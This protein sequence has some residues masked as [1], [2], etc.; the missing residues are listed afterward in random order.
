MNQVQVQSV[1]KRNGQ[2]VPFNREKITKRLEKLVEMSPKLPAVKISKVVN[3]TIAGAVNTISTKEL[4]ELSMANSAAMTNHDS[5]YA[6]LAS[7]I[8]ISNLQKMT[9]DTFSE[10]T[11]WQY[12][13]VH[14]KTG[15]HCPL[16]SEYHHQLIKKNSS[17][18]DRMVN[19]SLDYDFDYFGYKTMEKGYLKRVGSSIQDR[20]SYMMMRTAIQIH[21][22]DF[23]RVK[24]TYDFLSQKYFTHATPTLSNSCTPSPQL[25]SCF[26]IRNQDDSINGLFNTFK[27][28]AN[29]SKES[30]GIGLSYSDVRGSNSY[31]RGTHGRSKGIMRFAK[32]VNDI[33]AAVDQGG[34]RNGAFSISIEPWHCDVVAFLRMKRLGGDETQKCRDLFP[35]MWIPDLFFERVENG[36]DWS[37]FCPNEAPG[38]NLVYGE[39]FKEL[40][41]KYETAGL[42]REKIN[43]KK[44]FRMMI[45]SMVDG[46]LY[47]LSKDN[48]NRKTNHKNLGT[49]QNSNLCTEIMQFS[50]ADEIS[51]CTLASVA[52][53]KF[54]REDG[55]FDFDLLVKVV[56]IATRNLD[57]IIDKNKYPFTGEDDQ[58]IDIDEEML[59]CDDPVKLREYLQDMK[60]NPK[61]HIRILN[62]ARESSFKHRSI[63]LGVQGLA[64]V[65]VKMG[66][67]FDSENA[68]KLNRDIFE[69]IYYAALTE[70]IQLAKERGHYESY[71]GSPISKGIYQFDMWGVSPSSRWDWKTLEQ[72]RKLY[73]IRNS[74]LVAP[75]P[76][77][78]TSHMLGNTE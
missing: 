58:R 52:L 66:F 56:R 21:E 20:P 28:L 78:T 5:D 38:L 48:V 11:K 42:A 41:E 49:I 7:R 8:A 24:E 51:V 74:L 30:G 15:E 35:A 53:P 37:L 25:S 6:I 65:F 62:R 2:Q 14:P 73:G 76:T 39:E 46:G 69:T 45:S 59:N 34:K 57:I 17:L 72:N 3:M 54:V 33:S 9:P 67:A 60:Q 19:D 77:K 29:I 50:S 18:Y 36:E 40:Y 61:K 71:Q 63:G 55:T 43:A 10:C 23:E 75:M 12:N 26:L 1:T 13:N 68:R 47:M 44:L 22:E 32:I 4:D 31:I 27:Q 64:D 70:S 16:I